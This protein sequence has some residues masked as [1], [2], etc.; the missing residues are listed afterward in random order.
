[1]HAILRSEEVILKKSAWGYLLLWSSWKRCYTHAY[2][3]S[4]PCVV[5]LASLRS[6]EA[7]LKKLPEAIYCCG[8]H[9]NEYIWAPS[10]TTMRATNSKFEEWR[11]GFKENCLTLSN[12]MRLSWKHAIVME[13][14]YLLSF[15]SMCATIGT[16]E[17]WR[18][19]F[20]EKCLRLLVVANMYCCDFDVGDWIHYVYEVSFT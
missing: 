13:M 9:G 20:K 10:V 1:M 2:Q 12:K 15:I 17:E 6:E 18:S 3:V 11:S 7:I 19:K 16:F 4:S 5:P 14:A 8:C